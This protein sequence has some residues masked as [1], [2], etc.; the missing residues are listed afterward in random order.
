MLVL[1]E[2]QGGND[3]LNTVIPT[4]D[5]A[6]YAFRPTLAIP[7]SQAIPLDSSTA[8]HPALRPLMPLWKSGELAVVRGVG[9]GASTNSHARSIAAWETGVTAPGGDG[10]SWLERALDLRAGNARI[11]RLDPVPASGLSEGFSATVR[12]AARLASTRDCP[13]V[14]K[15][16]MRGYDMHAAQAPTHGVLLDALARGIAQLADDLK[17]AGRWESALV[18]TYSEF[19]RRAVE[20]HQGGTDHGAGGMQLLCG[21]AIRGGLYGA[22]RLLD[23]GAGLACEIDFRRV[24]ASVLDGWWG[25]P[26]VAILHSRYDPLPVLDA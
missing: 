26:S 19:G 12:E 11:Q 14:I 20:N 6:Y 23:D 2:L 24:Y 16:S 13:A 21:G 1:I 7:A 8:L 10:R 18:M 9:H 22:A 4:A 15:L 25:I 3:A 5:P 17:R